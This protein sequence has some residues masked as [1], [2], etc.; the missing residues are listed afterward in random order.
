MLICFVFSD[1]SY[2]K[3]CTFE[4]NKVV[5]PENLYRG[6]GVDWI[7]TFNVR[8]EALTFIDCKL[9]DS[10]YYDQDL[11]VFED[12]DARNGNNLSGSVFGEG[13]LAMIVALL[14]LVA[15]AVSIFLIV[16]IKKKL[17]PANAKAADEGDGE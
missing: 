1:D 2:F 3:Y 17:A 10:T 15:S 11:M 7:R 8:G 14:A 13:S 6:V 9:S 4:S 5:D 12:T 16:D